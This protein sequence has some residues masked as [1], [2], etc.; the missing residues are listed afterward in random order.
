MT[1]VQEN[2]RDYDF[3]D[4]R[5]LKPFYREHQQ[6]DSSTTVKDSEFSVFVCV[7]SAFILT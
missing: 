6:D 7:K 1:F 2:F 4:D 5:Y 3:A